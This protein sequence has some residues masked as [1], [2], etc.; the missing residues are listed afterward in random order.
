M[1][2]ANDLIAGRIQ[3]LPISRAERDEALAYVTAGEE[4]VVTLRAIA[5]FFQIPQALKHS[6]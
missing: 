2:P 4:L 3:T 5:Q 6:H 1:F